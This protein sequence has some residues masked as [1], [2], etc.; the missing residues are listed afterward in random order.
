MSQGASYAPL[1]RCE[2]WDPWHRSTLHGEKEK[3]FPGQHHSMSR[4]ASDPQSHWR[5][6]LG[7]AVPV[8]A[9]SP[10]LPIE[11]CAQLAACYLV[12]VPVA[13]GKHRRETNRRLLLG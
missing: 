4:Y 8:E 12:G 11:N 2:P 7:Q 10:V 9:W 6:Y 1:G 5:D 13:V 3:I